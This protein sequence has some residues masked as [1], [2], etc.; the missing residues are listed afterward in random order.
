MKKGDIVMF[1]D[2]IDPGDATLRWVLI[3]DTPHP[4]DRVDIRLI[5]QPPPVFQFTFLPIKTVLRGDLKLVGE[6]NIER[7]QNEVDGPDFIY[8]WTIDT[9]AGNHYGGYCL[10]ADAALNDAYCTAYEIK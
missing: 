6:V 2:V 8:H 3:E 4:S 5:N 1:K 10:T 9:P 7:V